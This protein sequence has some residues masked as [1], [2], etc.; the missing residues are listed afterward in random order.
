MDVHMELLRVLSLS[1]SEFKNMLI[2]SGTHEP[3]P[4]TG[5]G[6][7]QTTIRD[8]LKVRA[9]LSGKLRLPMELVDLILDMAE[10]WV[11]SR[12][13]M[14]QSC[15]VAQAIMGRRE[16][17]HDSSGNLLAL[18]SDIIGRCAGHDGPDSQTFQEY[19]P[20]DRNPATPA[21][22]NE[23]LCT[24]AS[25][26]ECLGYTMPEL[27]HPVRKLVFTI[28]SHDQGWT[29][30][31]RDSTNVY[32]RSSTWFEVG[33]ERFVQ[34]EEKTNMPDLSKARTVIPRSQVE[35]GDRK[36]DM[37]YNSDQYLIQIN[38]QANSIMAQHCV[39]WRWDDSIELH[40]GRTDTEFR[41]QGRSPTTPSGEFVRN[42]QVGDIITIWAKARYPGWRNEVESVTLDVHWAY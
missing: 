11:C 21:A 22:P 32:G 7:R 28:W 6:Q 41:K 38:R 8:V 1:T 42:L 10:Y 13:Q 29:S 9:I 26:A 4:T 30:M 40:Q 24:G 5:L 20:V 35:E 39:E 34:H 3:D 12:T 15:S 17:S 25:F 16:I 27:T 18:R 36:L 33:L 37:E 19:Q 14:T 2:A 31:K 23:K